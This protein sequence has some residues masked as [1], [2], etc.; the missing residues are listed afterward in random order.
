MKTTRVLGERDGVVLGRAERW[1]R[2]GRPRS[3]TRGGSRWSSR[4]PARRTAP[5]RPAPRRGG[6]GQESDSA[7]QPCRA[8]QGPGPQSHR[9]HSSI[10][11]GGTLIP[12]AAA[13]LAQ[14]W[15]P[16]IA[17]HLS[18]AHDPLGS[19]GRLRV[20]QAARARRDLR[21]RRAPDRGRGRRRA[22]IS[23][24][25]VREAFL[26]LEGEGLLRLYPKRGALV[27]PV[28]AGEVEA[29]ME[30]RALVER[31]AFEKAIAR[32][33]DVAGAMRDRD[34][35]AGGARR[36]RRPR[37]VRRSRPRVPHR[38]SS[39]RPA[40][41]IVMALYDSLRDRQQRM[42]VT[43]LRREPRRLAPDPRRAPGADGGG[44]RRGRR[45]ALRA[46]RR[47]PAR[48]AGVVPRGVGAARDANAGRR[49]VDAD[50]PGVDGGC[51]RQRGSI[52]APCVAPGVDRHA[53]KA[54]R[55]PAPA[56]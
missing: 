24:T 38:R 31:F 35:A 37:R 25:P 9:S 32:G 18:C 49:A 40:T 56:A 1:S 47:A 10:P 22:R 48:D 41:T 34:R 11:P 21:R 43:A 5:G 28:S 12:L 46:A 15:G 14:G 17:L 4:T 55:R 51:R 6:G 20:H 53:A 3:P 29:V 45:G 13:M 33:A 7:A 44:R 2:S 8:Q 26:R 39:P 54:A 19:E 36:R 27:V 52:R 23:R 42:G 30:T 16:S 50:D